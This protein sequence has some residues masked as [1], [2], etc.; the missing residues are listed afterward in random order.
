MTDGMNRLPLC[1]Q[2]WLGQAMRT[3][4]HCSTSSPLT[5]AS[6]LAASRAHRAI[7]YYSDLLTSFQQ[8][9]GQSQLSLRTVQRYGKHVKHAH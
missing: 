1:S 9:T 3:E 7:D 2:S 6:N 8:A 5:H 4:S